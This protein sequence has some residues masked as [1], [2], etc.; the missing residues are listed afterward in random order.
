MNPIDETD[1]TEAPESAFSPL[2]KLNFYRP[3]YRSPERAEI[4]RDSAEIALRSRDFFSSVTLSIPFDTL[5]QKKESSSLDFLIT[6]DDFSNPQNPQ[7]PQW[8]TLTKEVWEGVAVAILSCPDGLRA[9]ICFFPL[10][11]FL[12][13][14]YAFYLV[15]STHD[16][17]AGSPPLCPGVVTGGPR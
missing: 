12:F 15:R 16:G 1:D 8:A 5:K 6:F 11:G 17:C 7:E 4:V 14:S 2:P 10:G 13:I 3:S 9:L